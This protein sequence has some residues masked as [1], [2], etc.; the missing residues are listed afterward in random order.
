[1]KFA[2]ISHVLPPSWSGQAMILFKL[3][4]DVNPSDYI[5]ISR[6]DYMTDNIQNFSNKLPGKYYSL[7]RLFP[8]V[9]II[10]KGINK[11]K[12]KLNI[13]QFLQ[14]KVYFKTNQIIKIMKKKILMQS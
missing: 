10:N 1:M 5:L 6:E 3:L 2:I 8:N 13:P 9:E 7:P 12:K 4:K 11:L 14:I